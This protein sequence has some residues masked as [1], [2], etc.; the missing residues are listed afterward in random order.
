MLTPYEMGK[1]S[2]NDGFKPIPSLDKDFLES[3]SSSVDDNNKKISEWR[4]GWEDARDSDV[5]NFL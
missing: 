3:L 2:F 4:L 5:E 1:K